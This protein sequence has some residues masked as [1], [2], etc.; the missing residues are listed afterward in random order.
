MT[1]REIV[2]N[3]IRHIETQP[4]PYTLTFEDEAG[5]RLDEWYGSSD[6]RSTLVPY[7]NWV[8]I[9]DSLLWKTSDDGLTHDVFGGIWRT[10]KRPFHQ[11]K[12]PCVEPTFAGLDFPSTDVFLEEIRNKKAEAIRTI[13]E[14]PDDFHM[15]HIRWGL[16]ELSWIIR[17]FENALA[18]AATE[19]EFYEELIGRLSDIFLA[20]VMEFRDIPAD[21]VMFGDD[22]GD[23]RGVTL[24]PERWRRFLKPAWTKIYREVHAQ[25]KYVFSHCCGSVVD[26]MPDI[27]EMGMD[28]LES[29][30]PEA[31][32]MDPYALKKTWGDK[33]AFW[34]GLGCQSIVPFGTP[35]ELRLEIAR[36]CKEMGKGGGYILAPAKCLPQETPAANTA[37]IVEAFTHQ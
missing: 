11:V 24:G 19:P 20:M 33:I 7:M 3:Q 21:C 26:I 8:L 36:L 29:V 17:G 35:E 31:R 23:Q 25:G 32:G 22:W 9:I 10:D 12:I 2:L 28:V 16:F 34:G 30:Q 37:A 15:L 5:K 1:L 18:D 27:V 6:W 4:V 14:T 13:R